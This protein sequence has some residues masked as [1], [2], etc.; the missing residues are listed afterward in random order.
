LGWIPLKQRPGFGTISNI[1]II[2]YALQ[3][4]TD[5]FPIQH[6]TLWIRF[7]YVILGIIIIGIGSSLYITC[8]LGPGPRD[9]LMTGI[10]RVTG[11]RVGRVR[12]FIEVIALSIGWLLGGRVGIGTL[13]FALLIGNSVAIS[14]GVV[15]KLTTS[16]QI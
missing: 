1:L 5:V 16:E 6:H 3:I 14:L 4:G 15:R 10:H 8:G 7:A 9:G 2:S 11:V 12:L 13:M